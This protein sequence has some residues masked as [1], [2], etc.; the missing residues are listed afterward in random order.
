MIQPLKTEALVADAEPEE[1]LGP[2]EPPHASPSFRRNYTVFLTQVY[3]FPIN[4][5]NLSGIIHL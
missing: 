4:K 3:L 1:S 5:F 2:L